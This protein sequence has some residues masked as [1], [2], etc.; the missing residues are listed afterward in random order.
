MHVAY[1]LFEESEFVKP[2]PSLVRSFQSAHYDSDA[3]SLTQIHP[4]IARQ[5]CD[6]TS[7]DQGTVAWC[8]ATHDTTASE[9]EY[10]G[11]QALVQAGLSFSPSASERNWS[12]THSLLF[13]PSDS[14][15]AALG[16]NILGPMA[17]KRFLKLHVPKISSG[18]TRNAKNP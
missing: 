8:S 18:K 6:P 16:E 15:N 2:E 10:S 13:T 4:V 5:F 1:V 12:K 7:S 3:I 17:V 11:S 9:K 14:Q